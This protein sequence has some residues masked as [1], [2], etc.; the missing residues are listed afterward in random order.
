MQA[1][2]S[3]EAADRR[4]SFKGLRLMAILAHPDDESFG[5]GG[6]LAFYAQRGVSVH[7]VC[8]TRGEAGNV[9][10]GMMQGFKNTAELRE[11]ELH[12][13][14]EVLGL[15]GVHFLDYRDSGMPGSPDNEHPRAL[16]AAPLDEVVMKL[17]PLLRK[18][19]PQV[20]IT[21]DPIGGYCH[22]DHVAIHRAAVQ[23]FH[24]AG[25]PA[26]AL[27]DPPAF[28]PQKLYFHIFP[29]RLM[30]WLARLLPWFGIDP[31]RFGRNQDIDLVQISQP[32]YPVHARIN[33]R[34]AAAAKQQASAC[35]ASQEG[36]PSS[37]LL[38]LIFRLGSQH[39][40]YMRA[41]PPTPPKRIEGDLFEGITPD[42]VG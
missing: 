39:D 21:F 16:A 32:D 28:Q 34:P 1:D 18:W 13:A 37:G 26:Y 41:H 33:Y 15:E 30:R 6:T 9:P 20:V 35:H 10:P 38:G 7:L 4:S 36:P 2:I 22:P 3:S 14:A 27:H 40:T 31:Q 42:V 12:C 29:R 11:H 8:A 25:D 23:A 17:V 5:T 24:A 19:K